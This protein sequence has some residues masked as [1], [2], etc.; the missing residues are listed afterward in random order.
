MTNRHPLDSLTADEVR[1]VV[2]LVRDKAV[3]SDVTTFHRIAVVEPP[4]VSDGGRRIELVLWHRDRRVVEEVIVAP[5]TRELVQ[6]R[7]IPGVFPI[8]G[9]GEMSAAMEIA[10]AD[11]R[12][13]A[14][15]R[16][17]GVDDLTKVQID[18]WPTGQFS[19]PYEQDLRIL[20]C[21]FFYR[22][23]PTDNGY[24]R[25]IDGLMAHVDLDERTVVHVEDL[26][27]WPIPPAVE[28]YDADS[29]AALR[30]DLQPIEITQPNGV[31]F[32]VSGNRISWQG[33]DFRAWLDPTEGLV[34][35]SLTYTDGGEPRSILRR[36][37]LSE[38]VVPY[39]E[40]RPTQ[41]FKNALDAG[42][43]GLGRLANSL[44]LGCDC[45]GEITYL[46]AVF[47]LDNGDPYVVKNAICIHEEDVG[48]GWKHHD[49]HANTTEVRRARRLV[50]SSIH[51]AGNYEY[52]FFWYF[53]LDGTIEHQVKLTGIVSP[54]GV[55]EGD[56][57]SR[58]PKVSPDVAASVHHHW[59]CFRLDMAV[60]GDTNTVVEVDVT[61]DPPGADNPYNNA[62]S[63]KATQLTRTKGARRDA[64]P[65]H[66]RI[67]KI[68]NEHRLNRVGQ[69]TA[70]KLLPG[71][72][73]AFLP[74]PKS[75]V[76]GRAGFAQHQVW[77]TPRNP[78]QRFAAGKYATQSVAGSDGLPVWAAEDMPI[79]DTA[80]TLWHS[81]G[82][83][84]I[85]RLEDY[86][87]MPVEY[88]GFHLIPVGFFDRN[89]ALDVPRSTAAHC[90]E[91]AGD[92]ECHNA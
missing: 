55:R 4:R 2:G 75:A 82:V 29:Q 59:F 23:N 85:P 81:F 17:R 43:I 45:L 69:P 49:T 84:H 87:V 42:E 21:L 27:I 36:A 50:V 12:V 46:D 60:D 62:F 70:Y 58:A 53:Y 8:P 10:R 37:A 92:S 91:A 54:M 13:I 22:E 57:L 24:S 32:V 14:A 34:I 48:I 26:G 30:T 78:E 89:P 61:A 72:Q 76:A 18:P 28:N 51:T 7:E 41:A 38:M 71:P 33:W 66:S 35:H 79:E 86:P 25:P 63:A 19:L 9:V 16:S 74:S 73:P 40:T 15:L 77:V 67:W 64:A 90:R 88:V 83:T 52:G 6:R 31:S 80:L 1:E 11:E 68:I 47:N 44:E 39:G 20:R 3:A 65:Q 5:A 56:D